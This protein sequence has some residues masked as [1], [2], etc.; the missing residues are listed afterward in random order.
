MDG[1]SEYSN[2]ANS[3]STVKFNGTP[4]SSVTLAS[5]T[6]LKARVPSAATTGPITVTN[7]ATPAGTVRSA[8]NYTVN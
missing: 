3:S 4:A 2:D 7:T 6:T 5:P 1:A 8:T